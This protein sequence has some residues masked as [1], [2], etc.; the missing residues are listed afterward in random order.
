MVTGKPLSTPSGFWEDKTTIDDSLITPNFSETDAV[1][2]NEIFGTDRFA[3]KISAPDN[4]SKAAQKGCI[5][6]TREYPDGNS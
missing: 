5:D 3:G 6:R 4:T 1:P 2:F